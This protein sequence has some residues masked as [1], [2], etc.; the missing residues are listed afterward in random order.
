M[1]LILRNLNN[2]F[3]RNDF[4]K[5]RQKFTGEIGRIFSLLGY[6]V[7]YNYYT[8]DATYVPANRGPFPNIGI[9]SELMILLV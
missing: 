5:R 8:N 7:N 9:G 1:K 4:K 6:I 2:K 3:A